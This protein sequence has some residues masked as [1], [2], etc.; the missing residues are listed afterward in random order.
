MTIRIAQVVPATEVP[1][2]PSWDDPVLTAAS[3][4]IGGPFGAHARPHRR[5]TPLVLVMLLTAATFTLGLA[6]KSS[7]AQGAWWDPPRQFANLCYSDLPYD[8]TTDGIAERVGPLSDGDGRYPP[9]TATPPTALLSYAAGVVTHIVVGWPNTV[10]RD[11]RPVSEVAVDQ[12]V[13]REAVVYVGVVGVLLLLGALAAA[14][15]LVRTHA[16][17]PWDAAAFAAAPVLA[18]A[19]SISWSLVGVG[20]VA[21]ALWAW[22]SRRLTL[23]GALVGV[24]AAVAVY[25]WLLLVAFAV[26]G[27]R[28]G[29]AG[30]AAR[31]AGAAAV[32]WVG[33]MLPAYVVAPGQVWGFLD[34]YVSRGA[35]N[36]SLWQVFVAF[37]WRPGTALTN[38]LSLV[39]GAVLV[40][41]VGWFALT[42]GRRPR[43]PQVAL[44]L[45]VAVLLVNKE[46]APQNAL[47]LLP[48]AALARPYWRDLLIWQAGEV[49]YW[50][51][52][53]W[54][55]GGYTDGGGNGVDEIY[56]LA[57]GLRIAA[58]LWLVG[59]VVRDVR[60]PW[61]DPVRAGG[62][63]DDPAG[64]V[65]DQAP[66]VVTLR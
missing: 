43:V 53:W 46:Y 65:V 49:F 55:L 42:S 9:P 62:L 25:P 2:R 45:V 4:A 33:L 21:A 39:A 48:L 12:A 30:A 59:V 40:A 31:T 15:A 3:T 37:G 28:A 19:G 56:L 13:R 20:C 63:A 26:V 51:A 36:G 6:S 27:A 54:H 35:G 23:S 17:R 61:L 32:A 22:S 50:V 24:G 47:W 52:I 64:G 41:A 58:Q 60:W 18:L 29:Q 38:Q 1:H 8:Y 11:D 66:D 34:D 5:F 16:T 10:D 44:L 57:I 14:A 7:C